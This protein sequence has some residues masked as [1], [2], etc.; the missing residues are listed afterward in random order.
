MNLVNKYIFLLFI[1]VFLIGGCVHTVTPVHVVSTGASFDNGERNSGFLGWTTNN[2]VTYAI[3]SEHA[4]DRYN[5]LI[6]IYGGRIIPPIKKD[7]GVTDNKTN[8][9]I[10]LEA[11]SNFS[12]MNRWRKNGQ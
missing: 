6:E 9:F 11:L 12:K 7:Y 8:C 2:S 5:A 1:A 3:I 4:K 10:T